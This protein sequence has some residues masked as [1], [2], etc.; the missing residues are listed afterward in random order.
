[1]PASG[2]LAAALSWWGVCDSSWLFR[3]GDVWG[4]RATQFR[5]FSLVDD[6]VTNITL[7]GGEIR[8]I[9]TTFMDRLAQHDSPP[10][11][12]E[13]PRLWPRTQGPP[14]TPDKR[15]VEIRDRPKTGSR[16]QTKGRS[17]TQRT[18]PQSRMPDRQT[19]RTSEVSSKTVEVRGMRRHTQIE[20]PHGEVLSLSRYAPV[21]VVDENLNLSF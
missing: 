19:C 1:M 4:G 15:G 9:F 12:G 2:C 13:W 8:H 5:L 11:S 18:T 17:Q 10:H 21:Q 20:P 7:K 16:V 6:Y 3:H 14:E